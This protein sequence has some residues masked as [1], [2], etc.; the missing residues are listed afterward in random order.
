[1]HLGNLALRKLLFKLHT[2]QNVVDIGTLA[3]RFQHLAHSLMGMHFASALMD[4]SAKMRSVLTSMNAIQP[5]VMKDS[6]ASILLVLITA[7]DAMI[8]H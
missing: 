5:A 6:N 1:M 3:L 8:T 7:V 2:I 4:I